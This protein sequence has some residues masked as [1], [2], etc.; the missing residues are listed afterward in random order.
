MFGATA[1]SH[2]QSLSSREF[3]GRVMSI[4]SILGLGTTVVGGPFVGL[5]SQVWNP[6]VAIALAGAAT[7]VTALAVGLRAGTTYKMQ[8]TT[9]VPEQAAS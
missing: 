7:V 1:N 3:R 2:M 4:Y 8:V 5:V 6:R 9:I